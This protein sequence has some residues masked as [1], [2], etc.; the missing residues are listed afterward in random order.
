VTALPPVPELLQPVLGSSPRAAQIFYG[1]AA[2]LALLLLVVLWLLLGRGP[3]R[4]RKF[5]RARRLLQQGAWQEALT[6]ARELQAP[7]RLSALWR[8]RLRNLEGEC[9]RAGGA[10]ALQAH[11]YETGQEHALRAAQLLNVNEVEVRASVIEAILAEIRQCF[12]AT[13]GPDTEAV[14]QL[15]GRAFIL[16]SHCPEAAFWQGLCHV[17]EGKR[18]LALASLQNARGEEGAHA[19]FLDPLLYL[20]ALLLREDQPREALR[21]LTEA[22]RLDKNC[23]L[24]T[25]Q[26]STAML[27]A[28]GDAQIAVRAL[29]RALGPQGLMLWAAAP[30][31]VW[32]EGFPEGRSY[33]R[34]LAAKYP[35]TCPL[36]GNDLRLILRQGRT[37]LAQ[38]LYRLGKFQ[39]SADL[40][41]QVAQES[42]PSVP[43]L[44]GLGLALA[45]LE[46][47][48]EAFKHLRTAHDLEEPK[49]R[50]TAGYLALCGARAKPLRSEDKSKNVAW[51]LRLVTRFTAPADTE[52]AGLITAIFAEARAIGLPLDLDD[53]LYLCEHLL[54]VHAADPGAAAAY[55]HLAAT[56]PDALRPEYAWLYCRAAQQHGLSD[57]HALELFARTFRTGTE[58][59]TFFEARQ[60]DFEEMEFAYLE[61]SAAQQPGAFPAALGP[62]YPAHGER[63]LRARSVRLEQAQQPEAALATAVVWLKLAPRSAPAHDR[64]AHL[65]YQ[66]GDLDQTVAFLAGWQALEPANPWPLLRQSVIEQQRG[67]AARCHAAIR[68]AL[69][70]EPG[71]L[72]AD[73]AFL[74]A[75]LA[76]KGQG[77][78]PAPEARDA[79][80]TLLTECLK[81]DPNHVQALWC[82]AAVRTLAGDTE[83][84]AAQA[85]A[86]KRPEVPQGRFH[87]LAG[88]CHLAAGDY[89]AVM[90]ACQRAAADPAL[91]IESAYVMGW[92]ALYREDP[93]EATLALRRVAGTAGNPSAAHAQALLGGICFRQGAYEEAVQWWKAL[94]ADKRAAWQLAEPL[95][96]TLF[97]S[98]LEAFQA[99]QHQQAALHLREAGKWGLRDRRLGSLL[100]LTLVKA[101]QRLLYQ[102]A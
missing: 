102:E 91:A 41:S 90:E 15:I 69:D 52:W 35:Y 87:L 17:R 74:G 30:Q 68:Q 32:V 94:D 33:I 2:A 27:A 78:N 23:P 39:E 1:A 10:A 63:M 26:L 80:L 36:W 72:R 21:Y 38:G 56:F 57:E 98:A 6:L 95:H 86:M 19:G 61:R 28:G 59:R 85:P 60:W 9:H 45:R 22:N 58:A 70:L 101:G 37:A 44:R 62:E 50:S 16:Q 96:K 99:E 93:E 64:L 7:R 24:V 47:Y 13:S 81:A 75:R 55:H 54:S 48:D 29:Q 77:Q 76:L 84:L 8:G 43:V 40:F 11:D 71:R 20:G 83:G 3:R 88:I 97:L 31:R 4:R 73:I 42:A 25:W 46:R 5:Q 18:D 14:H 66:R 67:D 79:A 53:Q 51:A 34:R 92:A 49:E 65:H 89:A 12:A 100:M 82:L